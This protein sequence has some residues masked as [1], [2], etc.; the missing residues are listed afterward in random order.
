MIF[1]GNRRYQDAQI[2]GYALKRTG[3]ILLPFVDNSSALA[4][5]LRDLESPQAEKIWYP[6]QHLLD[7]FAIAEKNNLTR[8][9][10]FHWAGNFLRSFVRQTEVQLPEQVILAVSRV[11]PE[12]HR[13]DVGKI[14]VQLQGRQKVEVIDTT[15]APCGYLTALIERTIAGYG[16]LKIEIEHASSA[17]RH[18]GGSVC[19]YTV[20]W[21]ENDLLRMRR[22]QLENTIQTVPPSTLY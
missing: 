16:A 12:F 10:G 1:K 3:D 8:R 7:L 5:V 20:S 2:V 19:K 13:G 4:Q 11:F 21:E 18:D 14:R 6:L 22:K 17:C 9:V 15:Y